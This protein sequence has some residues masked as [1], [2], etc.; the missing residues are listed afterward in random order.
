MRT[1]RASDS[2]RDNCRGLVFTDGTR[3]TRNIKLTGFCLQWQGF[4]PVSAQK[5]GIGCCEQSGDLWLFVEP[6]ITQIPQTVYPRF[7]SIVSQSVEP[8]HM[9]EVT[10]TVQKA[11]TLQRSLDKSLKIYSDNCHGDT[12]SQSY[13]V[14]KYVKSPLLRARI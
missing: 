9:E 1:R 10:G 12:F 5:A 8:V 11:C 6:G 3:D 7:L 14:F 13:I 4:T 2:Q